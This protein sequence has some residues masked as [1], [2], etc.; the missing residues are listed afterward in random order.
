MADI[1][2]Y[3]VYDEFPIQRTYDPY[4]GHSWAAGLAPFQDGN[5]QESS[6]EAIN[7]WNAVALWG[8]VINNQTLEQTGRWMLSNEIA[9]AN[10]AWRNVDTSNGYLKEYTSPVASLSF[11]GKRTYSTFFSDESNAKL[12]IQLI[13]MSP[14]MVH[15]A[16]DKGAIQRKLAAQDKPNDYNVALGDYLIMYLALTDPRAAQD[17]MNRQAEE[18][19]DDANSRAYL[20]AWIYSQY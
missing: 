17:A 18:F 5:N 16:S 19:I 7:A 1:A 2:S 8:Q 11:G 9:T 3:E 12:G 15:F 4:S 13:P 20:R 10:K 14:V 6:S